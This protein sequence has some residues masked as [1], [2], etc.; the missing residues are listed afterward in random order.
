MCNES[1]YFDSLYVYLPRDLAREVSKYAASGTIDDLAAYG[2]VL[3]QE[4]RLPEHPTTRSRMRRYILD[5]ADISVPL[6]REW[7]QFEHDHQDE[8]EQVLAIRQLKN[9]GIAI[10]KLLRSHNLP[11]LMMATI[12]EIAGKYEADQLAYDQAT[13]KEFEAIINGEK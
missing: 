6:F 7:I 4:L 3:F 1:V 12:E 5:L 2:V 11:P 13:R 8:L 10:I 9:Y